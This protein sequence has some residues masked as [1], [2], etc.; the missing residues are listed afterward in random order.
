MALGSL[1]TKKTATTPIDTDSFWE[2]I[3][4][5]IISVLSKRYRIPFVFSK[6]E[7][8]TFT[9]ETLTETL[10]GGGPYLA[11]VF[12]AEG[13]KSPV[14]F[15]VDGHSSANICH[16]LMGGSAGGG[17]GFSEPIDLQ[18]A[19]I[20]KKLDVRF[21][22]VF[23]ELIAIELSRY[24]L[25]N[26]RYGSSETDL[27]LFSQIPVDTN[28]LHL[29]LHFKANDLP[30]K[31]S[32]FLPFDA[33]SRLTIKKDHDEDVS[34][35]QTLSY[36]HLQEVEVDLAVALGTLNMSLKELVAL[37][38]GELIE[39]DQP[40]A[41]GAQL[42]VEGKFFKSGRLERKEDDTWFFEVEEAT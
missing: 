22:R 9:Y 39:L 18:I 2:P 40:G 8:S 6:S 15:R 41:Q 32:L 28:C 19:P 27:R 11:S 17:P 38:P 37:A 31:V 16:T 34:T 42:R 29:N 10:V 21:M 23:A 24:G 30:V 13:I 26:L 25:G 3:C 14:F 35:V 36:M 4:K 20:S 33:A 12:R 7:I 5:R 1:K